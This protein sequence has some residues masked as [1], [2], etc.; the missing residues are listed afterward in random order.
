M[1]A[2]YLSTHGYQVTLV[3]SDQV[4]IVGVGE[5]TLPAM[6]YF[7]Q[8]IG[9]EESDWMSQCNAVYKLGIKHTEWSA[10]GSVWWHWFL[11]DRSKQQ[12]QLDHA[13]NGTLPPLADLEYGY[14]V[15]ATSF[16]YSIAKPTAIKHG[17]QHL[18]DHVD[19]VTVDADGN[20]A[21]LELASGKTVVADW[22]IDCTG[23]AKVLCK[24]VGMTYEPYTELINDRA[25]ACP[26]TALDHVNPY[27]ITYRK[28][29]GWIW[30]ISLTNR[31]GVGYVYSSQ[32]ISDQEAVEEYCQQFPDTDRARIRYLKFVPEKCVNPMHKN[33]LAVGLSAGFI[34]PLEATSLFLAQYN[35]M[36][37]HKVISEGRNADV[38]NRAQRKLIDEIYLY[39]LG[40]YTLVA[41]DSN[42]YWQHY[43][44]VEEKLD[45]L[46]TAKRIAAEPDTMKWSGT[47]L[48]FPYNWW[49]MLR[50][51]GLIDE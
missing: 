31:R 22:Y 16:G 1:A 4:D 20:V 33:V 14:H 18:V 49:S 27:T 2:A 44:K 37:F 21:S 17:C 35:I 41:D 36:N 10:P 40:H 50:G 13:I 30:E 29:A 7:C 47:K 39:V 11:Y 3:E 23:W 15:D 19:Q 6:N 43:K 12:S 8:Q 38:F 24:A 51:Y 46:S 48:F 26:Q 42:A 34:E 25:I 45:I 9:L 32:H 28:S 5:S